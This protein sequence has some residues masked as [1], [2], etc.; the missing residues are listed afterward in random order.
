MNHMTSDPLL[1][2]VARLR[3]VV[4]GVAVWPIGGEPDHRCRMPGGRRG[5]GCGGRSTLGSG[6]TADRT[7]RGSAVVGAGRTSRCSRPGPQLGFRSVQFVRGPGC[8]YDAV[9]FVKGLLPRFSV[10]R[11]PGSPAVPAEGNEAPWSPHEGGDPP[12]RM[13]TTPSAPMLLIRARAQGPA[14]VG[15]ERELCGLPHLSARMLHPSSR[16][17]ASA[18]AQE[19]AWRRR[20]SASRQAAAC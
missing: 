10:N 3:R 12:G 11:E 6:P 13:P 2:A 18:T 5:L 9:S 19:F 20:F 17:S 14:Q 4:S 7:E 1:Q 8:F 16:P 15:C